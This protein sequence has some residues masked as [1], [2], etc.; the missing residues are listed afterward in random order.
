M[1]P[2]G[3]AAAV[4][5]AQR[6]VV[7]V[8]GG[9]TA[10]TGGGGTKQI[11]LSAGGTSRTIIASTSVQ[12]APNL[13]A[14]RSLCGVAYTL[15][16]DRSGSIGST[17]FA[18]VKAAVKSFVT[19]FVGTPVRL[20]LVPF[21][22]IASTTGATAPTRTMS[23]NMANQ[24]EADA[25]LTLVTNM[26]Y[27]AGYAN[28]DDAM[29]RTFLNADGTVAQDLPAT[30]VFFTDGVPTNSRLN[31]ASSISAGDPPAPLPGYSTTMDGSYQQQGF[32]RAN[33]IAA[34][35]R[36]TTRF[37]GVG[38]GPGV[39]GT[40][41]WTSRV[42]GYH[43]NYTQLPP[44]ASALV[45]HRTRLSLPNHVQPW[46]PLLEVVGHRLGG[47]HLWW[48]QRVHVTECVEALVVHRSVLILQDWFDP[49]GAC[50]GGTSKYVDRARRR[51][52][53]RTSDACAQ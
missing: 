43:Y 52:D 25:L 11:S 48:T 33:L 2:G 29:F 14:A 34:Q 49:V 38:V 27:P 16:I 46:F 32:Y 28:W 40:Q 18:L 1:P 20:K 51:F 19:M 10:A 8:N 23:Y 13:I 7:T 9:G 15:I 35:F 45:P 3:V 47:R 41:T 4:K 21:D 24:T 17:D 6:V 44:A 53:K 12:G 36:D 31:N 42:P 5:N 22:T 30:V 39:T 50:V 37:I 26:T